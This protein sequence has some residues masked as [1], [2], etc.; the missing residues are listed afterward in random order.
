MQKKPSIC[1][2]A[3]STVTVAALFLIILP[4]LGRPGTDMSSRVSFEKKVLQQGSVKVLHVKEGSFVIIF[5]SV[6]FCMK[7]PNLPLLIR[8]THRVNRELSCSLYP[9][10]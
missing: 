4:M 2:I 6:A 1:L 7:Y 3:T 10:Q 5:S 9:D 8:K